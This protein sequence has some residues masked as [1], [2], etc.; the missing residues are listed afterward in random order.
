MARGEE[1]KKGAGG[2][3]APAIGKW[4]GRGGWWRRRGGE[5]G[6]EVGNVDLTA[7]G[8]GG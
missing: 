6:D 8:V 3:R 1:G 4:S 7:A 5:D 2:R